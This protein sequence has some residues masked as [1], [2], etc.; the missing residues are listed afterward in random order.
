MPELSSRERLLAILD[1][2][3]ADRP[4]CACPLQT[5][6][7]EMMERSGARWPDAHYDAKK[8]ADL[9]YAA[10]KCADIESVRVPFCLTVE[11]EALGC[12]IHS[13]ADTSQPSVERPVLAD[14]DALDSLSV[15]DPSK[16]GRMPVVATA[17]GLLSERADRHGLPVIGGVVGPF[18]LAGQIRGIE[19]L[20]IDSFDDYDFLERVLAF[21]TDVCVAYARHLVANGADV[22]TLIDPSATTELIGPEMFASLAGPQLHAVIDSLD[23]PVVL[24]ICGD[25]T[26]I[27]DDMQRIGAK[28]ISIDHLVD[29]AVAR[30]K[31]RS[32]A[33]VGNINPIDTLLF[34]D[35]RRVVD[36]ARSCIEKGADI[37]APG[38]GISPKTPLD[39]I[40]AYTS[41][42]H[43]L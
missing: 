14:K 5:A 29:M 41:Y 16:T 42:A 21:T 20:L 26:E 31:V 19:T 28:G 25:T 8:M 43:G 1:G 33:L 35:A 4:S 36:E 34:G 13:G 40:R 17:L 6:T 11:A 22:I 10:W 2:E 39:N 12:S 18:T 9:A 27:L 7:L 23:V 24:H 3:P 38:C 37:L 30:E 32:A 15:P